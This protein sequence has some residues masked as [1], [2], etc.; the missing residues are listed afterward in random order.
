MIA[1]SPDGA[2]VK[3]VALSGMLSLSA[4]VE[5]FDSSVDRPDL[6]DRA[7]QIL[8]LLPSAPDLL[9]GYARMAHLVLTTTVDRESEIEQAYAIV[10]R[11]RRER[12]EA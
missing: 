3:A 6:L 10:R 9:V 4:E 12:K 8:C 7:Y 5:S 1:V 11:L 2:A